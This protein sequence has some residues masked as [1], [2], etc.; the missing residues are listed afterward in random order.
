[1]IPVNFKESKNLARGMWDHS[2]DILLY[3]ALIYYVVRMRFKLPTQFFFGDFRKGK[4]ITPATVKVKFDQVAGMEQAK[5]EVQEIVE[6]LKSSQEFKRMGARIPKGALLTGPPGTGKTM[7][8]K[9]CAR[10]SNASFY[11]MSGSD[12]IEMYGGVGSSRVRELFSTAKMNAPA[13]IFIDEIDTI[14]AK[15]NSSFGNIEK[16]STLNQLLVEMD[17]FNTD[18]NVIVMAATNRKEI[19][20][21]ALLRPGRFDRIIEIDLPD[22]EGRKAV[23]KVHLEP[24]KMNPAYTI[25]EMAERLSTLTPG[26]SGADIANLCNEA[27][28]LA[29]RRDSQYVEKSDFELAS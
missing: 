22:L 13:I 23:F 3:G 21:D 4:V 12:F 25:D 5:K 16:D 14:G 6:F 19:L 29:S 24:I 1:M 17:G 2:L 20:D 7:L 18:T 26:F 28:I 9:A 10:E 27:A 8:A 11:S 15:R